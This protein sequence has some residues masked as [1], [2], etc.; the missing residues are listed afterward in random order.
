MAP[1]LFCARCAA[2]L[3]PGTFYV[4]RIEAFADPSVQAPQKE[5]SAE[6]IRSQIERLVKQLADVSEREAMDQVHRQLTLHLCQGCYRLW[7]ENPA[8]ING[9]EEG[10]Y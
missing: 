10:S 9:G 8:G 2:E 1:T 3:K 7:I 4:V 6:Q 5:L